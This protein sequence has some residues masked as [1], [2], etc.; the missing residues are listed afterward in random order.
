MEI[1]NNRAADNAH[2][3]WYWAILKQF[4]SS[5]AII[6][7]NPENKGGSTS[8]K[9]AVAEFHFW[10]GITIFPPTVNPQLS[11]L[12]VGFVISPPHNLSTKDWHNVIVLAAELVDKGSV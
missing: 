10:L 3:P 2:T 7:L 6:I 4:L 9:K 12:V 11:N 5:D 1:T 8:T